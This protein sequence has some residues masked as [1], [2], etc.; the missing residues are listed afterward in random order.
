MIG[1][2]ATRTYIRNFDWENDLT[3]FNSGLQVNANNAK[4]YNNIGHFYERNQQ[5][6]EALNYFKQAALKDPEDLGAELNIARTLIQ[7][8][9]TDEAESLLWRIKP[10][11]R[12]SAI[13]NRIVPN[14]LNL[15]INLARVISMND[16]RLHEAE[17]V[18]L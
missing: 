12:S 15:W 7:L 1:A 6:E 16:T 13:R 17:S 18:S 14:Y 9:R 4:L 2:F 5:H 8:N 11:V 3:L 10:R